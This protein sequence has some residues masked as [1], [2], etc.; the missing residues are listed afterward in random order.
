M[1]SIRSHFGE[2]VSDLFVIDASEIPVVDQA[3]ARHNS[4]KD[5]QK[6][7]AAAASIVLHAAKDLTEILAFIDQTETAD[8]P[9]EMQNLFLAAK[10]YMELPQ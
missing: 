8:V 3:I 2:A 9:P 4:V 7:F 10:A 6:T 1:D 5:F